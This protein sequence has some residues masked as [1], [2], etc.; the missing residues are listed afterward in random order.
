M[1]LKAL[2][3]KNENKRIKKIHAFD[4]VQSMRLCQTILKGAMSVQ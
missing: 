2:A 3:L 1:C 4:D